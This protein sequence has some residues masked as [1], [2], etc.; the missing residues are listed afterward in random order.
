MHGLGMTAPAV[1][2]AN[3]PPTESCDTT[4]NSSVGKLCIAATW[5][6]RSNGW[7]YW[8]QWYGINITFTRSKLR[9]GTTARFRYCDNWSL[10]SVSPQA[11][12]EDDGEFWIGTG[13]T[14][15]FWAPFVWEDSFDHL[16]YAEAY[17]DDPYELPLSSGLINVSGHW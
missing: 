9:P 16:V 13:E 10:E 11:C 6:W 8:P 1:A 4:A 12:A 3:P 15:T 5:S 7:I 2:D 17:T 14:K